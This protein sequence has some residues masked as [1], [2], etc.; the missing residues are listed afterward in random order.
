M[1]RLGALALLGVFSPFV[2]HALPFG[3][4]P[5]QEDNGANEGDQDKEV[6]PAASAYVVQAADTFFSKGWWGLGLGA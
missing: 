3:A 1:L 6:E 4:K 2:A 5:D